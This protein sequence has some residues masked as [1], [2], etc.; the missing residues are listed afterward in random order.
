MNIVLIGIL[1]LRKMMKDDKGIAVVTQPLTS[2]MEN[3]LK[4]EIANVAVLSMRGSLKSKRD[5]EKEVELSC[6]GNFQRLKVLF[7]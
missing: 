3:K 6:L 1:C 5:E 4:S 2:I 7:F